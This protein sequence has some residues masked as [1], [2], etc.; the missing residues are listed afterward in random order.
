MSI[1]SSA[2]GAPSGAQRDPRKTV[3]RPIPCIV[4]LMICVDSLFGLDRSFSAYQYLHT[5]WTQEEGGALPA[6]QAMAQTADGYL[7]LGTSN[8]LIRFD[9][10]RFVRW[11]T[12]SGEELPGKDIRCLL[13]S[14]RGGLWIGTASGIGRFDRGRLIRY[15]AADRTSGIVIS[16]V[17][18]PSGSLWLLNVRDTKTSLAVLRQDGSVRT[19]GPADGLPD[20]TLATLF[21]DRAANLWIGT[22][23]GLCRWSPGTRAACSSVPSR[24]VVSVVG[25]GSGE[26]L[27]FD[28]ASKSILRFRNGRFEPVLTGLENASLSATVMMRD[29]DGNIWIGTEGQGLLRLRG[30]HVERLTRRDGLSSDHISALLEDREGNLWAGTER[31]IDQFSVPKSLHFSTLDGLSSDAVT[32]VCTTRQGATWVGTAGG[33]LNRIEGDRITQYQMNSGL[34]S[35]TVASLYADGGG[36]LWAGTTGGLAYLSEGRFVEMRAPGGAPLDRVFTITGD[37]SGTIWLADSKNRLLAIRNGVARALSIP[38]AENKRIYQLQVERHG[39]LWVGFYQ[40]GIV[41]L[42][43]DSSKFYG[44][45]DGLTGGPVQAI[46]EDRTGAIWVGTGAGLSRFRNG[47]WTAWTTRHGLPEGGVQA[48]VEDNRD[49]LWL[50]TANGLLRLGMAELNQAPDGSPKHLNFAQYGRSDG[51]RLA[52][53]ASMMGPRLA[54]SEDG[55]LWICTEDGIAVIDPARIRGNPLPPPVIIEQILVD[56]RLVDINSASEIAF[57]GRELQIAYTGLSLTAPERVR[58]RYKL[59]GFDRT[60]TD[61]GTRRNVVY[62]NLPPGRYRF[63]VLACNNDGVWNTSGAGLAFRLAPYFYQTTWFAAS[64]VGALALLIWGFYRFRVR[65]LVSRFQLVAQERARVTRELHDSLLQG[66]S[67][68]VYQLEA[69]ARLF[70]SNPELCKERLER[71]IDQADQSLGETRRTIMSMRLPALE[72]HTLPEALSAIGAQLTKGK[73]ITFHLTVR[74]LVRQLRYDVQANIY[75]IG[76][77]AITNAVNHAEA[78]RIVAQM[79]YSEEEVRLTVED[80]GAGFDPE[81][82]MEKK[83]HWGVAGM[84]ERAKQIGASFTLESAHGRGTKIGVSVESKQS[85]TL[86]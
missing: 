61:A 51:L 14:S 77:E 44:A 83:D 60:W 39:R 84:R 22:L 1:L 18:D 79:M 52:N 86:S 17:E 73:S 45:Q 37:P 66:F 74:G 62:V 27:V 11:E 76:R 36:R 58:F 42:K 19:Y 82:A 59:D 32:S 10:M 72:N 56:G 78:R 68:V 50:A 53:T 47:S 6:I 7:W 65:R 34:P 41:S 16:M 35:T 75:L 31:G 40:G 55:R 12:G 57:R 4:L 15:P 71:A 9:G 25:G 64:C 38:G 54:R 2:S 23:G 85:G 69:A 24:R 20:Q 30:G 28:G 33:G 63:H 48:I 29:R 26:L 43:E 13:S 67:G 80:D 8:G 21:Q 70:E 81:T 5:S 46:Y 49:G 3:A